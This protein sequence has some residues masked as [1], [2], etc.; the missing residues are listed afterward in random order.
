MLEFIKENWTEILSIV[1]AA[2]WLPIVFKPIIRSIINY[3]R[4]VHIATLDSRI[5]TDAKS[6]SVGRKEKIKGTILLLTVNLFI[7][8]ITL[9]AR[10]MSVKVKLKDGTVSNCEILDFSTLKSNNDDGTESTFDVHVKDE[11]NISRTIH[12]N[13]DNIKFIA[14]LVKS[15]TFSNIDEIS[16][17]EIR[18]FYRSIKCNWFSKKVSIKQSDFPTFNSSHLLD[19]VERTCRKK[20][21][22][23]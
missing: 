1:G 16:E 8:D 11:F 5:L 7:K 14:V 13:V 19:T 20:G 9:F 6:V 3:F 12:P 22:K 4:K 23:Q 2:A 21:E 18:L 15:A 17:I 10:N